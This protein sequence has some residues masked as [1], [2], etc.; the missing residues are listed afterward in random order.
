[1]TEPTWHPL[2]PQREDEDE[3]SSP[4]E[5]VT[6]HIR[7]Y[8]RGQMQTAPVSYAPQ[9]LQGLTDV[10]EQYGGGTYE[11]IARD[12]QCRISRRH[13]ETIAGP[14]RPLVPPETAG[15]GVELTKLAAAS[16]PAEAAAG[17]TAGLLAAIGVLGPLVL[18]W[19]KAQQLAA[20]EGAKRH[21]ELMLALLNKGSESSQTHVQSMQGL[22]S[23]VLEAMAKMTQ[24]GGGGATSEAF[25]K[26]VEFA[27]DIQAGAAEAGEEDE[28]SSVAQAI[29]GFMSAVKDKPASAPTGS[30]AA[31][32]TSPAAAAATAPP[33]GTIPGNGSGQ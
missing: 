11:F 21:N 3:D 1:M 8:E 19:L 7:R 26:G 13:R 30:A 5:I 25:M 27:A 14:S 18:E 32:T 10:Y 31:G 33:E 28:L 9:D 29:A 15:A 24:G 17:T 20:V 16:G 4:P 2:F 6:I 22:Y 12:S 23:S